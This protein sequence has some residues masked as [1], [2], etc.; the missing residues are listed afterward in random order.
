MLYTQGCIVTARYVVLCRPCT[1]R[2]AGLYRPCA[3]RWA[4]KALHSVIQAL[5][6]TG[7][8]STIRRVVQA[9]HYT[10]GF[11]GPALYAG[12]CTAWTIR[13]SV[14]IIRMSVQAL[15]YT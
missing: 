8:H 10:Q 12:L 3:L 2:R 13:R 4:E 9:L 6:Y 5:N 11:A 15:D 14:F 7:R 1:M